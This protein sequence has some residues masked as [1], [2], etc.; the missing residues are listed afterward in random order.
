[1]GMGVIKPEMRALTDLVH[2][3][4][5]RGADVFWNIAGGS[6]VY[7]FTMKKYAKEVTRELKDA[8]Y[9]YRHFQVA[10]GPNTI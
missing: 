4:R 7:V 2:N 6:H 5:G 3:I 1:M 10:A 8:D 9:S